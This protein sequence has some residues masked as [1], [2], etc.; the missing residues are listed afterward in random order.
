M[1]EVLHGTD[2][3]RTPDLIPTEYSQNNTLMSISYWNSIEELEAFARRP[4]HIRGLKFLAYQVNKSDRPHDLGVM[5]SLPLSECHMTQP[6]NLGS[7]RSWSAPQA[8]GKASTPTCSRGAWA[9][10]SGR[11]QRPR[12]SKGLLSSGTRPSST[13]CGV[14]WEIGSSSRR[15][16]SRWLS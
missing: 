14:G 10:F 8:T 16:M 15:W 6:D 3:G 2:L 9:V 5:V 13:A 4:V 12:H 1:M 7:T 11:C